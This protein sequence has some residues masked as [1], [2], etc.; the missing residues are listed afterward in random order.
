MPPAE[1]FDDVLDALEDIQVTTHGKMVDESTSKCCLRLYVHFRRAGRA[2][3]KAMGDV[4]K[5]LGISAPTLRTLLRSFRN[6]NGVV[7]LPKKQLIYPIFDTCK[8]ATYTP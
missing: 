7:K 1:N 3:A 4:H 6:Q 2:H 8:I 5:V